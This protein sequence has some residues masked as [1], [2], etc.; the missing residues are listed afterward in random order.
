MYVGHN[1]LCINILFAN[2]V[3]AS[4]KSSSRT[5]PKVAAHTMWMVSGLPTHWERIQSTQEKCIE[6]K[7][8]K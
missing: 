6:N 7:T 8:L 4:W 3:A 1:R 2:L 5:Q